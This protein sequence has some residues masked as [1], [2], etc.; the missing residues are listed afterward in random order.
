MKTKMIGVLA[1]VAVLLSALAIGGTLAAFR[2]ETS[3]TNRVTVGQL[4]VG[5]VQEMGEKELSVSEDGTVRAEGVP[6][7]R[8]PHVVYA[9]NTKDYTLYLRIGVTKYW[10]NA[11]GQ[12]NFY[13]NPALIELVTE[14]PED[15]IVLQNDPNDEVAYYYYKYPLK[16]GEA[17]SNVLD[18]IQISNEITNH[19]VTA[20]D[21]TVVNF[22]DLSVKLSFEADA[23]QQ[24]NGPA[25]M[26]ATWGTQVEIDGNGTITSV[27][28]PE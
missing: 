1:A 10:E 9:E 2:A 24:A 20:E 5:L 12:K 4:G 13:A 25:A 21:G 18:A 27:S 23:V 17:T 3:T 16:A 14:H 8:Y 22:T 19:D 28:I 6:G 11:D 26:L 15:W 7:D